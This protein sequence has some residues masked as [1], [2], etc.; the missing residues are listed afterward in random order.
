MII[1]SPWTNSPIG[2][3]M[4][5]ASR[6]AARTLVVWL[7]TTTAP[8]TITTPSTV[9][10]SRMSARRINGGTQPLKKYSPTR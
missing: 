10:S 9:V 7:E 2:M 4:K 3:M 1:A 8:E 5:L 6:L